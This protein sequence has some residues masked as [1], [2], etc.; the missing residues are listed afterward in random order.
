MA[1]TYNGINSGTGTTYGSTTSYMVYLLDQSSSFG[2]RA[3]ITVDATNIY[4]AWL[5]SGSP[6]HIGINFSWEANT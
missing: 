3:T 6:A 5:K 1:A 2:Q 4:L